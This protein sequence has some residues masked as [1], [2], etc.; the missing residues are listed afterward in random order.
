MI[1]QHTTIQNQRLATYSNIHTTILTTKLP[2]KLQKTQV[3]RSSSY[4]AAAPSNLHCCS[5][6]HQHQSTAALSLADFIAFKGLPAPAAAAC[7]YAAYAIISTANS[8]H[9]VRSQLLQRTTRR[10][11]TSLDKVNTQEMTDTS[12]QATA[13]MTCNMYVEQRLHTSSKKT[14]SE[15]PNASCVGKQV[16]H[17]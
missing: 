7:A 11:A 9:F 2:K 6:L 12:R 4:T 16:R 1:H 14:H 5:M 8:L 13:L 17:S 3:L 15:S 10:H